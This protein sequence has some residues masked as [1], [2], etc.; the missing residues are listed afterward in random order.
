[1]VANDMPVHWECVP[2]TTQPGWYLVTGQVEGEHT[3]A[4]TVERRHI[5]DSPFECLVRAGRDYGQLGSLFLSL[6]EK[7]LKM[8]S[9]AD[10]GE[11]SVPGDKAG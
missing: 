4:I 9:C 5:Q 11:C 3:T 1:M 2:D 10:P 7:I 6:A 8:V